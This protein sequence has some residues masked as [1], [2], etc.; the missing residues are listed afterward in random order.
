MLTRRAALGAVAASAL[1]LP[2]LAQSRTKV[3]FA[4]GGIALYG[5]MPF[6]VAIG[7]NLF[8]KHGIEPGH[9]EHEPLDASA[10]DQERIVRK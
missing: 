10:V 2:A 6:F 3:R 1:P 5:Y 4:G 9:E 8:P 7:Q